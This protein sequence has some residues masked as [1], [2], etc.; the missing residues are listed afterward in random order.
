MKKKVT[1]GLLVG[2]LLLFFTISSWALDYDK[3]KMR[4]FDEHPDQELDKIPV[5]PFNVDS[6][7][8]TI[9]FILIPN[10]QNLPI[11]IPIDKISTQTPS[12]VNSSVK[13]LTN[14]VKE[15]DE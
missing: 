4:K 11:L 7:P 6:Y 14:G 12:K 1:L 10:I 2:V 8:S 9:K 13:N 3:Y 5:T 15:Q